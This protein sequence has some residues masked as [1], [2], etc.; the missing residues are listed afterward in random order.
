[1]KL[2]SPYH[3]AN[4]PFFPERINKHDLLPMHSK[5]IINTQID[6]R[7]QAQTAGRY[8]V[9]TLMFRLQKSQRP[10]AMSMLKKDTLYVGDIM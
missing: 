8:Y 5:R 3:G 1:M 6:P 9:P 7:G 10:M 4:L 2:Y